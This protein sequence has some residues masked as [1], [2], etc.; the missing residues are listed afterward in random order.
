MSRSTLIRFREVQSSAVSRSAGVPWSVS[1]TMTLQ[2]ICT[3]RLA[4]LA[5]CLVLLSEL[6]VVSASCGVVLAHWLQRANQSEVDDAI[7]LQSD[8]IAKV[9]N[10]AKDLVNTNPSVIPGWDGIGC[11]LSIVHNYYQGTSELVNE[12]TSLVNTF[13]PTGGP[14]P[15]PTSYLAG[16]NLYI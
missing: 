8:P 9:L 4:T 14:A 10:Y 12:V 7:L 5:L 1:E 16:E 2:P 13:T 11:S 6:A 15:P 3:F